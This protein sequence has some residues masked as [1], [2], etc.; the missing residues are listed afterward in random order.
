MCRL[1][2]VETPPEVEPD[3]I[4]QGDWLEMITKLHDPLSL[5]IERSP[6][7]QTG[8]VGIASPG[9]IDPVR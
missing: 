8:T 1:G 2:R 5:A 3:I 4:R 7:G 9:E 6:V